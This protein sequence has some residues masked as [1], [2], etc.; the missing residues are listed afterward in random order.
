MVDLY[1]IEDEEHNTSKLNVKYTKNINE[2]CF[3]NKNSLNL[4]CLNIR[5]I[6]NKYEEVVNLIELSDYTIHVVILTEV[7]GYS[8]ENKNYEISGYDLYASNRDTGRSGGVFIYVHSSIKSNCVHSNCND[9]TDFVLVELLDYKLKIMGV[10]RQPISNTDSFMDYLEKL[11]QYNKNCIVMGDININL[12]RNMTESINN[13]NSMLHS[14]AYSILNLLVDEFATRRSNTINTIIDHVFTDMSRFK[15]ALLTD[16]SDHSFLLLNVNTQIINK[17]N[18]FKKT[19][20]DYK[21]LDDN[22][23][24]NQSN[25]KHAGT[26][27]ELVSSV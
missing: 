23:I 13:Y 15:Y 5:S 18:D 27:N 1:E 26:F 17:Y 11:L 4:F 10:Y 12:L 2:L 8:N 19:V 7:Q 20:I 3:K 14:H 25:I 9:N 21:Y 16:L 22:D 6:R 24:I